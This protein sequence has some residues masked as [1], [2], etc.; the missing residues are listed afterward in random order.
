MS[1][2]TGWEPWA[3]CWAGGALSRGRTCLPHGSFSSTAARLLVPFV[4]AVP[5]RALP[6]CCVLLLLVGSVLA[7]VA[8]AAHACHKGRLDAP[9]SA[10][11]HSRMRLN[12]FFH[13]PHVGVDGLHWL[14]R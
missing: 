10:G 11:Q 2:S 13:T 14:P 9:S 3:L 7:V 12:R 8:L 6:S 4:V 5:A 1:G